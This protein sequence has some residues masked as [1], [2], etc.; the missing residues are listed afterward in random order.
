MDRPSVLAARARP[1]RAAP[2]RWRGRSFVSLALVALTLAFAHV[3]ENVQ[4]D[5]LR[6]RVERARSACEQNAARLR[7]FTAQLAQ[8]RAQAQTAPDASARL[9]FT[10][11][12]AN[13][14]CLVSAGAVR[15]SRSSRL[16]AASAPRSLWDW[17]VTSAEAEARGPAGASAPLAGVGTLP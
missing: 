16:A 6:A 10:I 4:V 11:P 8:W 2:V 14:V 7:Q 17:L 1:R 13:Q 3:W 12:G 5:E 9:G 15:G